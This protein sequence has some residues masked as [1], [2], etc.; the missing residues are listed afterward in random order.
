M[1]RPDASHSE[2]SP[3]CDLPVSAS[4]RSATRHALPNALGGGG[5]C[6]HD[7]FLFANPLA[8]STVDQYRIDI[9]AGA[10]V[11]Q[12]DARPLRRKMLVAPGHQ[13]QQHRTKIAT[14]LRQAV[15]MARRFFA[16]ELAF[17]QAFLDQPVEP[18]RQ[19]VGGDAQALLEFI[20]TGHSV[21]G[22]A[23]DQDAPPLA[24][25]FQAAGDGAWHVDETL[26]LHD[27]NLLRTFKTIN[28][29]ATMP[30]FKSKSSSAAGIYRSP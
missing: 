21:E 20:E 17:Q 24:N 27:G 29:I 9:L 12:H 25:P 3:K 7:M 1:S 6:A 18:A 26:A 28:M 2:I 23:Q 10:A 5:P 16:V 15:F 30:V 22:V 11:E 19:H 13:R 4:S 8:G 14:A